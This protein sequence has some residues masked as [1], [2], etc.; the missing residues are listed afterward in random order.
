[1]ASPHPSTYSSLPLDRSNYHDRDGVDHN[2]IPAAVAGS[3]GC[4][5][6]M[7]LAL[8]A[9]GGYSHISGTTAGDIAATAT[10]SGGLSKF[11]SYSIDNRCNCHA[12]WADGG[13][14]TSPAGGGGREQYNHVTLRSSN[15]GHY[16]DYEHY[17]LSR[18]ATVR[19]RQQFSFQQWCDKRRC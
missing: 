18:R 9:A 10:V 11:A 12:C 16:H 8:E 14:S 7:Q 4:V 2:I 6:D 19:L 3:G 5:L 13:K 17:R 15:Q 1:M